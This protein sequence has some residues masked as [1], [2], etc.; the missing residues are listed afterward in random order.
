MTQPRGFALI[1][2]IKTFNG[3][4]DEGLILNER[5]GSDVDVGNLKDLW[6]KLGFVV[7]DHQDLK[8]HE[9]F[10]VVTDMANKINKNRQS[11]CFV[12]CLMT[13]GSMDNVYGSDSKAVG[14]K[15]ITDLFKQSNCPALEGKPKL[16]F[17]QAC[18]GR[19]Q[20]TGRDSFVT[21]ADN[22][23]AE[24]GSSHTEAHSHPDAVAVDSRMK[25]EEDKYE[26]AF[27]YNADPNEAHFLLGYSTAP[28]NY[29]ENIRN[30]F[31]SFS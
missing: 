1:I 17:I 26:S 22:Y 24:T 19:R 9:I 12:C 23:D 4:T 30:G 16:F 27:R 13:H 10:T 7:E 29:R 11:S 20:L 6:Q 14:I 3:E 15:S 2:N 31:F 25:E 28:G 5:K 18:R 8:A 21:R